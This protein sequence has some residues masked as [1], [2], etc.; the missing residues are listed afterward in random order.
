MP[1]EQFDYIH[2]FLFD[3]RCLQFHGGV[4]A[5]KVSVSWSRNLCVWDLCYTIYPLHYDSIAS[6]WYHEWPKNNRYEYGPYRILPANAHSMDDMANE[7]LFY[8]NS[9]NL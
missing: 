3:S 4:R 1:Q 9:Y 2:F 6:I 5:H 8:G 7:K